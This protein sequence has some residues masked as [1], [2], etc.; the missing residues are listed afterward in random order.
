[1]TNIG[2]NIDNKKRLN[3]KHSQKERNILSNKARISNLIL[4]GVQQNSKSYIIK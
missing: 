3:K 4:T 2:K 1:M